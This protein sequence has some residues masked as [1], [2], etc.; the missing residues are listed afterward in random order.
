M[1]GGCRRAAAAPRRARRPRFGRACSVRPAGLP[2]RGLP[3]GRSGV[4]AR[5]GG[6]AASYDPSDESTELPEK[7]D[8]IFSK[9]VLEHVEPDLLEYTITDL[10]RRTEKV[11]YHLIA[12]HKA[13]NYYDDGNNA[14]LI[15]ETPDWWQRLFR[16]MGFRIVAEN[17]VG[18]IKYPKGRQ[19]IATTKY[20][21]VIS[22]RQ[23]NAG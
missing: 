8:M 20:E 15:V 5:S 3:V 22:M 10:W 7:V 13:I 9:D 23:E 2:L 19:S 14:H 16:A 17:V 21:C 11:Q 12:C 4:S 1:T 18:S 6:G